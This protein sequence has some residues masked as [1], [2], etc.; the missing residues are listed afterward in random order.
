MHNVDF[1]AS[2]RTTSLWLFDEMVKGAPSEPLLM[3]TAGLISKPLAST[4]GGG[5]GGGAT[6]AGSRSAN[7]VADL[8]G[9]GAGI[10][11]A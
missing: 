5:G 8:P 6:G 10:D 11:A 2:A 9:V 7:A 3:A 4:V 1:Q